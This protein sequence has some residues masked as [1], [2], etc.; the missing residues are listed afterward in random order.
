MDGGTT[1]KIGVSITASDPLIRAGLAQCL[2][3]RQ[4]IEITNDNADVVVVAM[5]IVEASTIESLRSLNPAAV[6]PV[7]LVV[8]NL[9]RADIATA[10]RLG[11]R[12]V[13][14][15]HRFSAWAFAQ[16]IRAVSEGGG[17]LPV[18]MQGALMDQLQ[19]T[20]R[21][22]LAPLDMAPSGITHRD[23]DVLRL[24]SEGFGLEE[25]AQKLHFSERTV[26]NIL[27]KFMKRFDLSNRTHAV[28]HAIRAGLI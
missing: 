11:V 21:E 7:I 27:Y 23:I 3:E 26:K 24:V 10:V 12:A 6:K 14:W 15:R 16:A 17:F 28:A 25:I 22:V 18:S 19:R 2:D 13:L 5:D 9:W 20:Y 1:T 4:H 8:E